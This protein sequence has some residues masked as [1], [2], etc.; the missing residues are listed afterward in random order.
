MKI[1][2]LTVKTDI[3]D[4]KPKVEDINSTLNVLANKVLDDET[5]QQSSNMSLMDR[6]IQANSKQSVQTVFPQQTTTLNIDSLD[7]PVSK[8]IASNIFLAEQKNLLNNQMLFNKN[9]A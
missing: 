9:E 6:L 2:I 3:V 5:N 1:I 4:N 7:L 8:D